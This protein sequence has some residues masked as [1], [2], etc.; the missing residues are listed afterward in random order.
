MVFG[1]VL[2]HTLIWKVRVLKTPDI[3]FFFY[4]LPPRKCRNPSGRV[5]YK[6]ILIFFLYLFHHFNLKYRFTKCFKYSKCC[7]QAGWHS[8]AVVGTV[9]ARRAWVLLV[10]GS[11]IHNTVTETVK[12]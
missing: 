1:P 3:F 7:S 5:Q 4:E 8:A 11:I 9:T 10:M 2:G 6:V 12:G